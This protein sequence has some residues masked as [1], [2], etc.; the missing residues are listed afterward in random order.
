MAEALGVVASGIAVA[1]LATQVASSIIK[2]KN[3]CEHI[4]DVPSEIGH[5]REIDSLNLILCHIQDDQ[6]RQS[7]PA[8][9]GNS[10]YLKQSLELCQQ[11]STEL[12]I[13]VNELAAKIDGKHGLKKKFGSAKVVLKNEEIKKLKRRMK[14]AIRLLSLSYQC[15]TR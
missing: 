12:G 14:S 4:K 1:Q 15:H 10:V 5:L 6:A 8:S 7:D 3:Y 13:L 9:I 2:L 11:G